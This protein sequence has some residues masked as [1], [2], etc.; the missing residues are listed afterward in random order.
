MA[1][2]FGRIYAYSEGDMYEKPDDMRRFFKEASA[3]T[4]NADLVEQ[5]ERAMALF[6]EGLESTTNGCNGCVPSR[7]AS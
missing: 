6:H 3:Y 7:S 5:N 2:K 4:N 1:R